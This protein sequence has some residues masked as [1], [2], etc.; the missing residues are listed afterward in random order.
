V[1]SLQDLATNLANHQYYSG[2]GAFNA[3]KLPFGRDTPGGGDS[4][5]PFVVRKIDQRWSPSNM[6]DSLTPFGA[7]T[8]VTRTLKDVERVSKFMFNSTMG[9]MFLLKQTGLQAMNPNTSANAYNFDKKIIDTQIYNPLG[10]NT[11][12]EVGVVGA[13]LHFKKHGL[14]PGFSKQD[15]YENLILAK[16]KT[17]DNRMRSLVVQL[18]KEDTNHILKYAG[19]PE[20]IFGIGSTT[21]NRYSQ[22]MKTSYIRDNEVRSSI[23]VNQGFTYLPMET[24]RSIGGGGGTPSLDNGNRTYTFKPSSTDLTATADIPQVPSENKEFDLRKD[25]FRA[26]KNEAVRDVDFS[27]NSTKYYTLPSSDYRK[28]NLESR[29]GVAKVRKPEHR[30][31]Y[32]ATAS[33][34]GKYNFEK[35]YSD[36][37]N[38][39]GLYYAAG[40]AAKST[41]VNGKIVNDGTP[42]TSI[43]DIIKFRIKILDNDKRP[44]EKTGD[45]FGVYIV[46]RAYISNIRRN[47]VS[48]WDAYKY[49]G[50]GESFYAYDGFTETITYSFVIAA[51]SRAEMKPLYQKLNY[52]ISSMAPDY[53]DNL[54]RGNIAELTIGDFVLYQPGIITN[55]DMNIDEDSNW[56]IALQEPEAGQAGTDADMHELPHL[57]KCN[58]TFIPIYNFLPRKSAEAPFIGIDDP[59]EKKPGKMWLD[60]IGSKLNEREN[61]PPVKKKGKVTVG[62]ATKV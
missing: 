20:S 14:L 8:T 26:F 18:P 37:I 60:K 44:V 19:G 32:E 55:F 34:D 9:P 6:T 3:N 2:V 28:Y 22:V 56:E 21:I 27:G 54:M 49:V 41:D 40:P 43:R 61:T 31:K 15:S 50:R 29:I 51:S 53:R 12:A 38:A 36:R 13:G 25:D 58:M 5:Q 7:V 62:D 16:E 11:L 48:K 24:L 4:G 52:L 59:I 10:L 39:I 47:V 35:E 57:I 42:E 23:K 30:I 33:A 17:G 46:F 45:S 1:P